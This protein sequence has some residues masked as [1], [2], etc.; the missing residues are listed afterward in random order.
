MAVAEH[1]LKLLSVQVHDYL[2]WLVD[3]ARERHLL[4]DEF[5]VGVAFEPEGDLSLL[6]YIERARVLFVDGRRLD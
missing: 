3:E 2:G 6:A 1:I 5:V 4:V